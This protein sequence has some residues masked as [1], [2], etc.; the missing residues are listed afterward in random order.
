MADFDVDLSSLSGIY[1][2]GRGLIYVRDDCDGQDMWL[3]LG[4]VV[5]T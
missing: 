2:L 1:T 4:N 5:E 3:N